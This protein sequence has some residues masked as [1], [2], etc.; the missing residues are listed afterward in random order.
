MPRQPRA[1]TRPSRSWQRSMIRPR[2][3]PT[4]PPRALPH[5]QGAGG[6]RQADHAKDTH[7]QGGE[8]G[9]ILTTPSCCGGYREQ[10]SINFEILASQ[11]K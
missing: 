4:P 10:G 1:G 2:P 8:Q 6:D 3:T 5:R 9:A 7:H 11:L